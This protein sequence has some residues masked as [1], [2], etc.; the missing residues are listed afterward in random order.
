MRLDKLIVYLETSPAMKLLRSPNAAYILDFLHQQFKGA[1]KIAIPMSELQPALLDYQERLHETHPD[2][3]IDKSEA[4]LSTW[5]SGDSRW[6]HRFL[7]ANRNEP[8]FQLTPHTEDVFVFL[9]RVLQQ[10][11]GFVGTQS[12][13]RLVMT[14]LIELIGGASDDPNVRLT[15]LRE[16]RERIDDEIAHIER[17]GVVAKFEPAAIRERFATAVSLL[18]QVLGDFRAVEDRFK[19]ITQEVQQRQIAGKHPLGSILQFALDSED[20]LKQ[21]DQGVSFHEFVRFI[22]SPTQQEKLQSIITGLVRIKEIASQ[23]EGLATVRRMVPLLLAEAEKVMRT[24][25]RLTATLRRLLDSRSASERKRLAQLLQEIRAFAASMAANPPTDVGLQVDIGINLSSS[26][27]RTLWRQPAE[28]EAIDLTEH[29]VDEEARQRMFQAL[30]QMHR[31]DWR[32][33]RDH[34]RRL[35]NEYGSATLKQIAD[36]FPP[37]VGIIELLGYLQIA[38]DDGHLISKDE[39]E[40]II[41]CSGPGDG[42]KLKVT[43]P[44]TYFMPL[45]GQH[46]G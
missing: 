14:T 15:Q 7:E 19:E 1:G 25:Q 3:L 12:R 43:V 13:L 10:D 38:Q 16:E 9:D 30:A 27:S 34:V 44:L 45:E 2:A 36:E 42:Q 26:F 39:S 5:C 23:H 35:V 46:N 28:F 18:R 17:E 40:E 29:H 32:A 11:L 22:L 31:L 24:N 8:V 4:Y 33:M 41:L 20:V 6:I 37:S 21:D